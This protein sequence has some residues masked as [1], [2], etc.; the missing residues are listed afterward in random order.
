[1]AYAYW[2][3]SLH[4]RDAAF[5]LFFRRPPF[6]GG[7]T[8]AAGLENLI[9]FI[10][11]FR[12]EESD[13]KY[14]EGI[15]NSEGL[16]YF[17]TSF[18]DMLQKL[19]LSVSIDEVPEGTP[20]FPYEPLLRVEGPILQC[21]LL[22]T[23]LLNLINF[24]TLIATKA[25]RV[26]LAAQGDPVMEFG[27]RRAQ[28]IDGAIT[29]SRAAYI[30]GCSS[31][32]NVLAGKIFG[33]PVQGTQA[34]SWVMAFEEEEEAFLTYAKILPDACVLLVDTYDTIAGVKKAIKVGNWLKS[35]GKKL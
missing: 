11:N 33:I 5:H 19:R 6:H 16:P 23:P 10:E 1:M 32:S 29:A 26:C 15:K 13:L 8:I 31:T 28:G 25:A 2:K 34:H 20:V 12:F 30:G 24:P 7:F 27:V 14:L 21:Q 22:E 9:S 4:T 35:Q 18:L 17:D 3:S